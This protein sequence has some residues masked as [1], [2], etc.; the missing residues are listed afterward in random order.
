MAKQKAS[1]GVRSKKIITQKK[2]E[3]QEGEGI[4]IVGGGWGGEQGG[5]EGQWS[6]TLR[7]ALDNFLTTKNRLGGTCT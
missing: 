7:A 5:G 4:P 1:P 6:K 3:R 2:R